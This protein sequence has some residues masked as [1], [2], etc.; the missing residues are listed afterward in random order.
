MREDNFGTQ[1][2]I[3]KNCWLVSNTRAQTLK[4]C[5]YCRLRWRQCMS[6]QFIVITLIILTLLNLLPLFNL[7]LFSVDTTHIFSAI[8]LIVAAIYGYFFNQGTDKTIEYSYLLELKINELRQK[9]LEE[10]E[11]FDN[12]SDGIIMIDKDGKIVRINKSWCNMT[13]VSGEESLGHAPCDLFNFFSKSGEKITWESCPTD[14][15]L[16]G[17]NYPKLIETNLQKKNGQVLDVDL[18]FSSIEDNNGNPI[19]AV[20]TAHDR[21]DEKDVEREKREFITIASHNLRT[22][23]TVIKGCLEGFL[24]REERLDAKDRLFLQGMYV[25]SNKL[26]ILV[27]ELLL[28]SRM[29]KDLFL[30][31]TMED[32]EDLINETMKVF[33]NLAKEK[34]LGFV[35]IKPVQKIPPFYID[36]VKIKLLLGNL[37][38]NAIKYTAQGEVRIELKQEQNE[39]LV[40]VKDTGLGIVKES[41]PKLFTKF[42]KVKGILEEQEGSGLGLYV[43][44]LIVE[45]HGG[46]IWVE[47]EEKVG[48]TFFFTLPI[49]LAN[50]NEV[51]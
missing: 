13:D 23:L 20:I 18:T 43:A 14:K 40:A 32:L 17:G 51:K 19:L 22:P 31:K 29:E 6:F 3:N 16:Q 42:Y 45:H 1:Q 38:D 9:M 5:R 8:I 7:P 33:L 49:T 36:K 10:K 34:N 12:S 47:S 11:I 39:V 2:Y 50:P 37:I 48:T 4:R 27:E 21:T 24:S 15:L 26:S 35:F 44:K 30:Y 28:I 25:A 41:L 46:R